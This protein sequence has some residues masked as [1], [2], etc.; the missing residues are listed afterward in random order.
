MEVCP[1]SL[2]ALFSPFSPFF[3]LIPFI[4]YHWLFPHHSLSSFLSLFIP[5]CFL[6]F[7][8]IFLPSPLTPFPLCSLLIYFSFPLQIIYLSFLFFLFHTT[9]PVLSLTES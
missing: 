5:F 6:P 3:S 9:L 4:Y 2:F 8:K 1:P 7:T